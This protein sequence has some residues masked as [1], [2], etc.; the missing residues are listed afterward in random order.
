MDSYSDWRQITRR[1]EMHENSTTCLQS[2]IT[3]MKQSTQFIRFF[4]CSN[5][6]IFS[7]EILFER[8]IKL[9][10]EYPD[11]ISDSFSH[12]LISFRRSIGSE[13]KKITVHL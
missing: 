6:C 7:E 4:L 2:M 12:Q 9:M 8:N 10:M 13:I 3:T 1:I 11:D 5:L